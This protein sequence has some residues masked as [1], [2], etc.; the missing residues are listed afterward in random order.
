MDCKYL[1]T[2]ENYLLNPG[3]CK[4]GLKK[5][6]AFSILLAILVLSSFGVSMV[7]APPSTPPTVEYKGFVINPDLTYTFTY[8]LTAGSNKEL[9]KF[10]LYS[11]C[12]IGK[13]YV[14]DATMPWSVNPAK[15]YIEFK[16]LGIEPG[17]SCEVFFTLKYAY[18]SGFAICKLDCVLFSPGDKP[19]E[20]MKWEDE[21]D[22]PKCAPDFVI[23]E[24][25]I[26]TLGV[27]IPASIAVVLYML[28]KGTISL[29]FI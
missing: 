5:N 15:N 6:I 13:D 14:K 1:N 23:P 18:Y 10:I 21:V 24:N 17:E 28:K 25:P 29:K 27:F 4:M 12:F 26:G 7:Y 2:F 9:K 22:G 3:E 8:K 20:D 19:N 16:N 11:T